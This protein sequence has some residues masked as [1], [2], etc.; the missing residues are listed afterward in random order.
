[1]TTKIKI[2]LFTEYKDPEEQQ[3]LDRELRNLLA[4][5]GDRLKTSTI[6][7]TDQHGENKT[8][9]SPELGRSAMLIC[10][11]CESPGKIVKGGCYKSA[12]PVSIPGVIL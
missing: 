10:K 7:Y 1:M 5:I 12:G 6:T 9:Q 8:I 4:R 3:A 11:V 2:Q